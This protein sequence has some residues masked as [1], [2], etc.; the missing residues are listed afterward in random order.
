MNREV[1]QGFQS[2]STARTFFNYV[3]T[4]TCTEDMEREMF[5]RDVLEFI[6]TS[7]D[8]NLSFCNWKKD[9]NDK[10]ILHL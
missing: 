5:L 6:S 9:V 4:A 8:V 7:R 1:K 2:F 3:L 10:K